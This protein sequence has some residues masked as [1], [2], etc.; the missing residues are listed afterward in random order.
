[1]VVETANTWGGLRPLGTLHDLVHHLCRVDRIGQVPFIG[2]VDQLVLKEVQVLHVVDIILKLRQRDT[3]L[4]C[5]E[6]IVCGEEAQLDSLLS[7][8]LLV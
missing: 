6:M 4:S 1:V 3:L 2:E 5:S 8:C 7:H